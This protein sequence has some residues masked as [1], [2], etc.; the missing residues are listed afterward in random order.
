MR[1]I[2][3]QNYDRAPFSYLKATIFFLF[4][5]P[6]L[7]RQVEEVRPCS[8]LRRCGDFL[9]LDRY[10]LKFWLSYRSSNRKQS[11]VSCHSPGL[12]V[13]MWVNQSQTTERDAFLMGV[14]CVFIY[15]FSYLLIYLFLEKTNVCR[16]EMFALSNLRRKRATTSTVS[17]SRLPPKI[18]N[19]S[20]RPENSKPAFDRR[21]Q[22]SFWQMQE[23]KLFSSRK[24]VDFES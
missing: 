10:G 14:N 20:S 11:R 7:K 15:L 12:L 23:K 19:S 21:P 17:T 4:L 13:H 1:F 9:H 24:G 6:Y 16:S 22:C 5:L 18:T 8:H 2:P 3:N